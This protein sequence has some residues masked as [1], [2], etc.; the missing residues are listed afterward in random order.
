MTTIGLTDN[1]QLVRFDESSPSAATVTAITGVTG[2]LLGI[3][4][5][6]VDGLLYGI[7][8]TNR[9]YEIDINTGQATLTST[10]SVAFGN[11]PGGTDFNPVPDRLRLIGEDGRNY[12]VN[13]DS[14]VVSVDGSLAYDENEANFG[15]A[16]GVTAAAYTNSVAGATTTDLY[17]FDSA[18]NA[19]VLQDPPNSGILFNL[20]PADVDITGYDIVTRDGGG[21]DS[22]G[23]AGSTLYQVDSNTGELTLIGTVGGANP[24]EL[25]DLSVVTLR[26]AQVFTLNDNSNIRTSAGGA[27]T[28]KGLGGND[29]LTGSD[30]ID[31][32]F[33]GLGNDT[34]TG[35]GGNDRLLG[36]DGNDTLAGGLGDDRIDGGAGIDTASYATAAGTLLI[37]LAINGLAQA[38]GQGNDILLGVENLIGSAFNDVLRGANGAANSLTGGTGNDTLEGRSGDDTLAGGV[39]NDTALG[40]LGNDTLTGGDGD[41][42]LNGGIGADTMKGGLGN[43]TYSVDNAGDVVSEAL[44]DGVDTVISMVDGYTLTS[45]VEVLILDGSGDLSGNGNS[46]ANTI[47]GNRGSN[48]LTGGCGADTIDGGIGNDD[49]FGGSGHD[50]ITGGKGADGLYGELGFDVFVFAVHSGVDTLYDFHDGQDKL[51]VSGYGFTSLADLAVTGSIAQV[52]ADTVVT[53][54]GTD[55]VTLLDTLATDLTATNFIFA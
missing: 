18:N 2:R 35:L 28:V 3:D 22:Y 30:A 31:I 42:T 4:F 34:L 1:N 38:T 43:D 12:R 8:S 25:L 54:M 47:I 20:G 26:A 24:I 55:S 27:E 49:I 51:D 45:R 32:L 29:T 16:P 41:D 36:Q 6:P 23:V 39:G 11:Q 19:F 15:D 9:V 40:G 13:V 48:F 17:N 46:L 52:G 44:G 21:E 37:D 7:S 10:L 53:F 14:G 50:I 5:R 33:G